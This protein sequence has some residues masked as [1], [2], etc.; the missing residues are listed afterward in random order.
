MVAHLALRI[1][2]LLL[3][4]GADTGH[5][6][7]RVVEF[8]AALGHEGH[9]F[10]SAEALLVTIQSAGQF[11]TKVGRHIPAMSV[12]M[13]RLTLIEHLLDGARRRGHEVAALEAQLDAVESDAS[14]YPLLMVTLGVAMTA[15]SLARLFGA[16]WAVVGA[17]FAAGALSTL[18]R[19]SFSVRK[20]NPIG[21]A[22]L[23]V[24]VSAL[25]GAFALRLHPGSSPTL[26][27]V[28]AGMILVP[29][30]PL[31]NGVRDLIEGHAANGMVRL[32]LGCATVMAISF[33][34]V[35]AAFVAGDPLP[36]GGDS[37]TLPI[38]EDMLF[39]A[40]AAAGYATL[41]NVPPRAIWACI[42]CGMVGHGLRTALEQ[43]GLDIASAS[44]LGAAAAAGVA[45]LCTRAYRVPSVTFAF[46]GVVAMIPG[47]YA[48]RAGMGGLQLMQQGAASPPGLVAETLSLVITVVLVTVAIATGLAL[49]LSIAPSSDP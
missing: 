6:Q 27:L 34:L 44:L 32:S 2:R 4:N 48:F 30:V 39:S 20:I 9:F 13:R 15:A 28:A 38:G 40:L 1:G 12:D 42:L 31:I 11:R 17:A 46:P 49:A 25:A 24:F 3:V 22:F 29:G 45:D 21:A 36:V 19:R 35:L 43:G 23:T 10:I 7:R 26:C 5:T 16:E 8:I 41:F 47:S 33:G 14:G 37:R 18:L